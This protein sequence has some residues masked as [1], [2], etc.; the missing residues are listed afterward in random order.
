VTT[1]Y[2]AS[3]DSQVFHKTDCKSATKI[4]EKNLVHYSTRDEAIQAGK[5]P[6]AEC[7]P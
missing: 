4:S 1:G 5:K 3:V 6:C 7:Q 2:V